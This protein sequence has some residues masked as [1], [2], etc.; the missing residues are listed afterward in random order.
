MIY[1]I[2]P[3]SFQSVKIRSLCKHNQ[4]IHW[5]WASIHGQTDFHRKRLEEE[6]QRVACTAQ[7]FIRD[8]LYIVGFWLVQFENKKSCLELWVVG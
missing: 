6:S 7:G 5:G 2:G 3:E 1:N 4:P 8:E